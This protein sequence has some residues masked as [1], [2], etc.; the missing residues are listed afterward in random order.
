[1]VGICVKHVR[2]VRDVGGRVETERAARHRVLHRSAATLTSQL[3]LAS[4]LGAS[5][6]KPYLSDGYSQIPLRYLIRSFSATSFEP[7][8]VMEFGF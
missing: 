4:P 6:G 1:M 8:S 7:A 5:I 3:L 2:L